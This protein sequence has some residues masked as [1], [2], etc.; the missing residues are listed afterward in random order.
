MNTVF[1]TG[2]GGFIGSTLCKTMRSAGYSVIGVHRS[3][4]SASPQNG[5]EHLSIDLM[6]QNIRWDSL[7]T[8]IEFV[9]HLAA[10][11][12]VMKDNSTDPLAAYRK[13]NV[14]ATENLARHAAAMGVK[15]FVFMSSVKVNGEENWRSYT[16]SDTPA[17]LDS[18]G[19]SKM[20][21]E[22]TLRKIAA[23]T[24]MA[25]VILR[26]PL[27]YGPGVKANFLKLL[28]TVDRRIPLPFAGVKNQRSLIYVENLVDAI[29]ACLRHPNAPGQTF[30]V[31]DGKDVSTP[32]LIRMM[33]AMLHKSPRL[34]SVPGLC[35]HVAS[36][37]TGKGP[38]MDR[39][40]G[41]L[42][43]DTMKIKEELD[44]RPPFNLQEGLAETVAWF[45]GIGSSTQ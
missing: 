10:R 27:V 37:L 29:V 13:I 33:S 16:E 22:L 43:V 28:Q 38:V 24:G 23:E 42:T 18:Y 12:H 9:V 15:R 41:S 45:R 40:I 19:I 31:S 35:L 20:E 32:E 17:P 34:F 14:A 6:D 1:V 36:R 11:V 30:L 26:S 3:A 21:A 8:G 7:L 5:I 4:K 44:W 25:V 2:A 39:L